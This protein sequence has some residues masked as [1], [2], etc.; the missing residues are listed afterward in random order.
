MTC[1]HIE[2]QNVKI[3]VTVQ[4]NDPIQNN[5]Q[6]NWNE[7]TLKSQLKAMNNAQ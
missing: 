1:A 7:L 5:Q 4:F 6:S 3:F 2:S